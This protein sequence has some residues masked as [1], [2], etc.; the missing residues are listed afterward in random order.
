MSFII[1]RAI[2]SSGLIYFAKIFRNYS[3]IRTNQVSMIF[4]LFAD[5]VF[6]VLFLLNFCFS[7]WI[8]SQNYCLFYRKKPIIQGLRH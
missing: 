7:E 4:D 3:S 2:K 1:L 5:Y 8:I 6:W